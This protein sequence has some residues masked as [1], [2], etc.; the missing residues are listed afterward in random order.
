[1]TVAGIAAV[2]A[3]PDLRGS[4]RGGAD[5][6]WWRG[7]DWTLDLGEPRAGAPHAP[8]HEARALLLAAR[9]SIGR[10]WVR[11]LVREHLDVAW[12]GFIAHLPGEKP[13]LRGDHAID[14]SIAHSGTT[15]L[16]AVGRGALV[17]A[18]VEAAPFE[19]F[20]R[21][22]LVRRMCSPRELAVLD[23]VDDG[24]LRRRM[25]ARAWTVKE[26]VLKARGVGLAVD[27]RSVVVDVEAIVAD[28]ACR[29]AAEFAS[30]P[31]MS[32]VR[33]AAGAH[34]AADAGTGAGPDADA[35]PVEVWH[36]Q[37]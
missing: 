6:L 14:V 24:P 23:D 30:R 10:A 35:G 34:T 27:P 3:P 36:P 29:S 20:G 5:G 8:A 12:P 21:P 31:E 17:G 7:G 9:R 25:V 18:D 37:G 33:L 15:M 32:I 19:A 22:Q 16:V 1:M 4:V 2:P 26:A 11:D 28:V 13:R